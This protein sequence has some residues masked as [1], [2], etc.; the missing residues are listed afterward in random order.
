MRVGCQPPT[1]LER[2][3]TLQSL[4]GRRAYGPWTIED[5]VLYNPGSST[6]DLPTI[7]LQGCLNIQW[8]LLDRG[9]DSVNLKLSSCYFVCATLRLSENMA[10]HGRQS[11]NKPRILRRVLLKGHLA[12]APDCNKRTKASESTSTRRPVRF[13]SLTMQKSMP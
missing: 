11:T 4:L 5:E 12:V 8:K 3:E 1:L 10:H 7:H 2:V 9:E 6:R 13:L